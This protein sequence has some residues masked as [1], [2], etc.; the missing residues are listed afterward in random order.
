MAQVPFRGRPRWI[1]GGL[2]QGGVQI[3]YVRPCS[4]I[5]EWV[6]GPVRNL[7]VTLPFVSVDPLPDYSTLL[8]VLEGTRYHREFSLEDY[9]YHNA[10]ILEPASGRIPFG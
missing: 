10:G 6:T 3:V 2:G 1:V 8:W 7:G 9:S 4:K 5:W